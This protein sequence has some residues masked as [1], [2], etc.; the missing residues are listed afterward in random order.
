MKV[1]WR[2]S[3]VF[4]SPSSSAFSVERISPDVLDLAI[5]LT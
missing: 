4:R 1:A 5:L 2:S 3:T